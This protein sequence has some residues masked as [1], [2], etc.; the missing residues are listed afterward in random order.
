MADVDCTDVFFNM[1]APGNILILHRDEV[2]FT[3][4]H[5]ENCG[6]NFL[7]T[8][9]TLSKLSD[10]SWLHLSTIDSQPVFILS[11]KL[12]QE[13]TVFLSFPSTMRICELEEKLASFEV[14][15]STQPADLSTEI[16]RELT[17]SDLKMSKPVQQQ[18]DDFLSIFSD[19]D[20]S[21]A[22]PETVKPNLG[23]TQPIAL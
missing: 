15:L 10:A 2:L 13:K 8:V 20:K 14:N 3:S 6:A 9:Q 1:L 16:V 18:Q 17:V 21:S 4:C 12:C 19:L 7:K 23:D 5:P 22:H 11:R